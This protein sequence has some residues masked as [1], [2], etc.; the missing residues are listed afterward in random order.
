MVR[1]KDL[2]RYGKEHSDID[3]ST[4]NET[5]SQDSLDYC[6]NRHFSGYRIERVVCPCLYHHNLEAL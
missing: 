1:L 4:L 3:K 2:R 5:L 6:R